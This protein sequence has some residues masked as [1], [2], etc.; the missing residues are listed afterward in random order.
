VV[1]DRQQRL[2][3]DVVVAVASVAVGVVLAVAVAFVQHHLS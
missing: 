2:C 1:E 3:L